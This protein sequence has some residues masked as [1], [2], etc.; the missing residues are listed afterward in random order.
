MEANAVVGPAIPVKEQK[1]SL[2]LRNHHENRPKVRKNRKV[3]RDG[4]EWS[5]AL[6]FGECLLAICNSLTNNSVN[7]MATSLLRS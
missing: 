7:K 3:E 4:E 2:A 1:P 5:I 6:N